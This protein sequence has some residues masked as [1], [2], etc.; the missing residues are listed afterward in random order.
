[1]KR[2]DEAEMVSTKFRQI[3][4]IYLRVR[5]AAQGKTPVHPNDHVTVSNDPVPSAMHIVAAVT[6]KLWRIPAVK[7]LYDARTSK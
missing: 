4:L 5:C 3:R 6:V 2:I 1:M 7:A